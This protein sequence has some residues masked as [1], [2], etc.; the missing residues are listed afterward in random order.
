M[1]HGE[2]LKVGRPECTIKARST[3][4]LKWEYVPMK[5]SVP[6][7]RFISGLTMAACLL[8]SSYLGGQTDKSAPSAEGDANNKSVTDPGP[9]AHDDSFQIGADDVL[10]INVW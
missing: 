10:A 7:I 5:I 2:I 6:R 1:E 3:A 9:K 4:K 8:L